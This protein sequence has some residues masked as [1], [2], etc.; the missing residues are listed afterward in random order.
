MSNGTEGKQMD[1]AV[2]GE[3]IQHWAADAVYVVDK[4]GAIKSG[5]DKM[6]SFLGLNQPPETK[7]NLLSYF[8][9]EE[10]PIALRTWQLVADHRK[11]ERVIRRLRSAKG[12][13]KVLSV[14]ESPVL[15]GP[16]AN[17]IVGIARDVTEE[18]NIEEKLWGAQEN[19]QA[20]L[21]YAVRASMGLIKGYVFSL[22]KLDAMPADAKNRFGR[23]VAEEID[24]MSRNIDN[25]LMSRGNYNS[26]EE[27]SVFDL[28]DVIRETVEVHKNESERRQIIIQFTGPENEINF[29]GQ[30]LAISR[31]L[32][33]LIDF[34]I[35]R[36]THSGQIDIELRDSDEYVEIALR[37]NGEI[38]SQEQLEW[39]T[40]SSKS[41][42]D[43][44]GVMTGS[45]FDFDV[46]RLLSESLGGGILARA[47][48]VNGLELT[49]MLPRSLYS[50]IQSAGSAEQ[51][52]I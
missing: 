51:S 39:L 50:T 28:S 38:A 35:L 6:W 12:D 11:S 49:V 42:V 33:N 37:D 21:E 19:A 44:T 22:N 10:R 25:L 18:A 16:D 13:S 48:E 14:V 47:G 32:G 46:A 8:V 41:N 40:R 30:S 31:I 17:M 23:I 52:V 27:S 24:T 20:A 29:F 1:S 5:N 15:S 9:D 43:A 45:K 2:F 4:G 3:L 36:L 7:T 26:N 34:M